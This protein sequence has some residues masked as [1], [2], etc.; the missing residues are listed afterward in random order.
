MRKFVSLCEW[1]PASESIFRIN[2]SSLFITE[3]KS[4]GFAG[5]EAGREAAA[6]LRMHG[7]GLCWLLLVQLLRAALAFPRF[8]AASIAL[9]LPF[10]GAAV[11]A[12]DE[13]QPR[14]CA[15]PVRLSGLSDGAHSL[16]VTQ[17]RA[18]QVV[19]FMVDTLAPSTA[20]DAVGSPVDQPMAVLV[21]LRCSE[22]E[23]STVYAW[24]DLEVRGD[25]VRSD[26][27][28]VVMMDD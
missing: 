28:A 20:V 24:D 22:E 14:P 26:K 10:S 15:S 23:C 13:A 12:L 1:E 25:V 2:S 18:A 7:S 27:L 8:N 5:V 19:A 9:P 3:Q 17:G 11:C 6:M 4:A 16:V 21:Q